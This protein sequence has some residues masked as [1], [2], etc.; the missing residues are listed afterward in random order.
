MKNCTIYKS[1][2]EVSTPFYR[3]LQ[4]ILNRIKIGQNKELISAIRVLKNK[5][6]RNSL[7]LKLPAICF[8][9]TFT[10][11]SVNGL[12]EHSGIICLDFDK[13][14]T[15]TEIKKDREKF[16]KDKHTLCLFT[17]PSGDG[18]KLLVKIPADKNHKLYF[19]A[20]KKYYNND[21]F[22]ISGKDVSRVC[23]ES[24]DKDI[25]INY[26]SILWDIYEE[27]TGHK[28]IEKIPTIPLTDENDIIGKLVV[29]FDKKFS[30][31]TNRNANLFVLASAFNEYGVSE[32]TAKYFCQRYIANDFKENEIIR[33]IKSAYSKSASFN[34]K[35][36]EDN[37]K[38]N[39]VKGQLNSGKNISEIKKDFK[40]VNPKSIESISESNPL[41]IF[42]FI[43]KNNKIGIDNFKYKV[44]LQQNGFYKFYPDGSESFIFIR[45]ENNLIDNTTDVKVKDFVLNFLL[46]RKE[47]D[48]YQY[49]TNLPKYFKDDVLNT[50]DSIDVKFKSDTKDICY[51]YFNNCAVEVSS[52]RLKAIDYI[53]L[54]GFVWKKHIIAF[55]YKESPTGCD[56]SKFIFNISGKSEGKENSIRSTIGY[57]L[58]SFKN[59][60]NN[61][62]VILND[63]MISENP[64]G[65]TG[66]GIVVNAVSKLKRCAIIDG[67]TFSFQKSFPYQTVSAD[68]QII[69]FDD[70]IR[71]FPFEN[72]FSVVTEGITLEKKNK[73]AIKIPVSKSPKVM[74]TT[75]YAI[76]GAGNS[77]DRRKWEV[78]FSQHYKKSFTPHDEFGRLLFDEW[79]KKEWNCFY[80]YMIKCLQIFLENG[81][82]KSDFNNLFVR[83]FI[84]KTNYDFYEWTKEN[85]LPINDRIHK[86]DKYNEFVNE[87]PDNKK[88]LSQKRFSMWI[89]RFGEFINAEV[90]SGNSNGVRWIELK[91]SLSEFEQI[92][93]DFYEN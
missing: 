62:A 23:Y 15:E 82:I 54:D 24:Y 56:F 52:N 79:D 48:V 81:L 7:K 20:L 29:W 61:V 72:L 31:Q 41:D 78:E 10:N 50:L 66:K 3:P 36:F 19:E 40:D 87:Y 39:H 16:I 63:E 69:I 84:A 46:E 2:F 5:D 45:L 60:S 17:S 32:E 38:I 80:S 85:K 47:Y 12:K 83:Q 11:R 1:I 22:D 25:F 67:K 49:M 42:W 58:S 68:T 37:N 73:D 51:L 65:G 43:S 64:E 90:V 27:N 70:A 34:T 13:Y 53:D 92:T 71:N 59:G 18:L 4:F 33:T 77:F 28:Y 9:G 86:V 14:E 75:N 44:W 76:G 89:E 30:M 21:H 55:D 93:K 8:S 26:D 88:F 57:L 6:E 35:Y 91:T 74:I